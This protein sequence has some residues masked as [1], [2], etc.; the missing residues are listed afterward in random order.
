MQ[1]RVGLSDPITGLGPLLSIFESGDL[2]QSSKG[3]FEAIEDKLPSLTPILLSELL[4]DA[5]CAIGTPE[6]T[7]EPLSKG[8]V[9]ILAP[10]QYMHGAASVKLHEFAVGVLV[11]GRH[12]AID[13]NPNYTIAPPP[14]IKSLRNP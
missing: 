13:K 10:P 12:S 2:N 8:I 11:L 6:S 1:S 9:D 14:P 5:L 3:G 7:A 4:T